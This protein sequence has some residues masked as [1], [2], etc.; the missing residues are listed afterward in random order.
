MER[1]ARLK[2]I[3]W[4]LVGLAAAVATARFLFGLGAT[5]HLSDAT[6]WGLWVGF[7][8]MGGVALAAGG[9]VVTAT[10]YIFKL[11][12]F[13]SIVRPAVLTAFLGYVAVVVGLLFD[14][15]LPWNIWHMIIFWNPHSPLFEVGWCVML[16]LT[17]LALEFFPVPAEDFS[18]LARLRRF[19]I[20]LR[21]PL[22]ILGIML[23]TLHQSSLGSLF[24]TMPYRLHPLWYSPLLPVLFFIS[25]VGLG[26][27]M[28]IFESHFTAYLYRRK[29]ETN[30]LGPLGIAARWVLVIY[31]VLRFGDLAV[32]GQLH[33]LAS[34]GWLTGLFWVEIALLAL[35]PL[36]LLSLPQFKL[37]SSWQWATSAIGV[38]G[39]VL[40]RID[41][42]GLADLSRGNRLYLPAWTEIAVSLGIVAAA[43]LVFLFMIEHFKIWEQRPADPDADPQKLPGFSPVSSTWLGTPVIAGRVK[44]SL[45]FVLAAAVGFSFLSNPR[46]ASLGTVPTPVHKA[47]GDVGYL[48]AASAQAPQQPARGEEGV[49]YLDADLTGY[50]V[51]FYHQREIERNGGQKSCVLCHHMNLPR[52]K[53]SGCFECHRDMYLPSDSFRHDWHASPSGANLACVQCHAQGKTRSAQ[54]VKPCADCHKDLIPAEATIKIKTYMAP[55]YVDAMHQLCI[56]CHAKVAEQENK[57]E[58]ARCAECHKGH[59]DFSDAKNLLYRRR[60]LAGHLVVLPPAK[61]NETQ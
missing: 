41:V 57:P 28:V 7:D 47:R 25:A 33:Y 27:L 49:L 37:R 16:Y 52:D 12:R 19:L 58:V 43:T 4:M 6:P 24:L 61:T 10:V 55:A 51:T 5:T 14:L 54:N 32:R 42:G 31:L 44:Y 53:N 30:L 17:V 20:K 8:V 2:L 11:K 45:A 36:G 13:H 46:A 9:F 22:V 26:L 18:V 3:L 59:L 21:I 48:N 56:G 38:F 60:A 1:V 35:I 29:P 50:G 40:D 39:V 34:G 15:G 23:S